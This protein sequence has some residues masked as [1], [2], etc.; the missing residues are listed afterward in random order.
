MN[1]KILIL[2]VIIFIAIVIGIVWFINNSNNT[3]NTPNIDISRTSIDVNIEN[4]TNNSTLIKSG[5]AT[6]E[7][8]SYSTEIKDNSARKT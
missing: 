8:S 5:I 7:L 6:K 4:S 3:N 2:I 1:K